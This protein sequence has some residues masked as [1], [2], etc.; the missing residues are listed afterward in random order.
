MFKTLSMLM[1]GGQA[2]AEDKIRA[3][4]SIELIEQHLREAETANLSAK[5]VLAAQIQKERAETKQIAVLDR[6]IET[7]TEQAKAALAAGEDALATEAAQSIAAMENELKTRQE[8]QKD[9]ETRILRLRRTIEASH[10]R[11]VDLKHNLTAA[12][13]IKSERAAQ[14][15]ILTTLGGKSAMDEAETL[16]REI[17]AGDDPI[18]QN[19]ILGEIEADLTPDAIADR[20]AEKG[21]GTR[22]KISAQDVLAR[23]KS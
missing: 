15:K 22:E 2:R 12:R 14:G 17:E 6:Q 19:E 1:R 23:L 10:R 4:Y 21:F 16:M 5:S 11:L 7:L 3:T 20:L 8:T 18:E 9:L 13:A